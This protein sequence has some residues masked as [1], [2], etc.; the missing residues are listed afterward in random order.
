M[1]PSCHI[2]R[3]QLLVEVSQLLW[4][5]FRICGGPSAEGCWRARWVPW[6]IAVIAPIAA[7]SCLPGWNLARLRV[8][9]NHSK[10]A[11]R[12]REKVVRDASMN[13]DVWNSLS[14][15]ISGYLWHQYKG[16]ITIMI[17]MIHWAG[18]LIRIPASWMTTCWKEYHEL[19]PGCTTSQLGSAR[20][21]ACNRGKATEN[22]R[23]IPK[24][25]EINML[26][27]N[28]P[29]SWGVHWCEWSHTKKF[30]VLYF[31]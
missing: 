15:D 30:T 5:N 23:S 18:L 1:H 6:W 28:Q 19:A 16:F 24:H 14:L 21:V 8:H 10:Q 25:L 20:K 11:H 2:L 29:T 17:C 31:Q 7:M 4:L 9:T 22:D 3:F 13:F 27:G 12:H 26:S